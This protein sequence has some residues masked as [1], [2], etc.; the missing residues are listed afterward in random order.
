MVMYTCTH[1]HHVCVC[2]CGYNH[3]HHVLNNIC[4]SLFPAGAYFYTYMHVCQIMDVC[5]ALEHTHLPFD[6][7]L[8]VVEVRSLKRYMMILYMFTPV[9]VTFDHFRKKKIH[10]SQLYVSHVS[11][12]PLFLNFWWLRFALQMLSTE[13]F[14]F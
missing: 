4:I 8:D 14:C 12:H 10:A 2:V 6:F 13:W 7:A 1:H 5:P 9:L 11:I 3:A